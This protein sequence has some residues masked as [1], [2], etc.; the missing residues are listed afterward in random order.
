MRRARRS[1]E[2]RHRGRTMNGP[3]AP[4]RRRAG[5]GPRYQRVADALQ[6]SRGPAP[7]VGEIARLYGV[8]VTTAQFARRALHTR[9]GVG[10][11]RIVSTHA[12]VLVHGEGPLWHRVAADLRRGILS[13]RLSHRV[14]PRVRLAADYGVS[15]YTVNRAVGALVSQGLLH[16]L[17]GSTWVVAPHHRPPSTP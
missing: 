4:A 11:R 10:R 15:V 2:L 17:R 3:A 16:I 14:P 7:S 6:Q 1:A 9:Q 12:M 5:A 8:S 13:G